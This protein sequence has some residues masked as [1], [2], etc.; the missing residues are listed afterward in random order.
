M[1]KRDQVV[2]IITCTTTNWMPASAH[3]CFG[4]KARSKVEK[5]YAGQ[6]Q[7]QV[8]YNHAVLCLCQ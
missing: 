6:K 3:F 1:H 5:D 8:M 7:F 4:A 2:L